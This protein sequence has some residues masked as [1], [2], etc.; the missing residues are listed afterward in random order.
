MF[1]WCWQR[2]EKY[3][4]TGR[5]STCYFSWTEVWSGKRNGKGYCVIGLCCRCWTSYLVGGAG[6]KRW[7]S[8]VRCSGQILSLPSPPNTLGPTEELEF[9]RNAEVR[10]FHMAATVQH[11]GTSTAGSRRHPCMWWG[12]GSCW[13]AGRA[14]GRR[15]LLGI[16]QQE[17]RQ[18]VTGFS[19]LIFHTG[20]V[21]NFL[22]ATYNSEP[23]WGGNAGKQNKPTR[24]WEG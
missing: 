6:G 19:G 16:G 7:T 11:H 18:A 22:L 10:H 24:L 5:S 1:K 21:A 4:L 9:T 12:P 23:Y 2:W 17:D 13:L 14:S 15:G 3:S 8:R 20:E